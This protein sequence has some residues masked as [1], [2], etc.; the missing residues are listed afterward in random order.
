MVWDRSKNVP[1][2]RSRRALIVVEKAGSQKSLRGIR[3]CVDAPVAQD[4][5]QDQLPVRRGQSPEGGDMARPGPVFL[6]N[7]HSVRKI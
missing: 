3:E 2:G 1:K 4:I 6:G 5:Y 7:G